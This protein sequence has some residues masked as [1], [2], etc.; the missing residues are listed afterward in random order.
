MPNKKINALDVKVAVATDLMLVGD[1]STG[2]AYKST[3]ANLPLVPY[4]GATTNVN[5]GEFGLATGQVTLDTSP[6]GTA[7]VGTTRWNDTI[8]SSETTLK[9]GSVVLKNGVDLVA[10]IVNKVSPNATLTKAQYQAVRV[11]GAQG[12]RLAVAYAQANND[13]NSADTIG[14]VIETIATNQEGFIITVGQIEGINTT[15]SLQGETWADGDVLYLSPTTAGAITNIKPNGSTGHIVVIGYVEYAHANNGKIYVKTMN[16]WELDELHNVYISSP[17]NNEAL[18]YESATSLW[19]NKTIATA[20]GYTPVTNARTLTI[21]GTTYDLSADRSWT[22]PSANIYNSDGTLT[23]NRIISLGG[24][25]LDFKQGVQSGLKIDTNNDVLINQNTGTAKIFR[26][27][28]VSPNGN[29]GAG[30]STSVSSFGDGTNF[31]MIGYN[32]YSGAKAVFGGINSSGN[33]LNIALYG[34]DLEIYNAGTIGFKMFDATSNIVLQRGG[35][36]TDAGYRLDVN[37]TARVSDNLLVSKNQNAVTKL[38]I[39]NTTGG[40]ASEAQVFLRCQNGA[41]QF[42]K[43]SSSTTPYKIIES[44]DFY[45]YNGSAGGGHLTFL[46]DYSGGKIKF[47]AG[48]ASTAQMT[49]TAAGRLLLGSTTEGTDMLFVNGTARISLSTNANA[50]PLK[51]Q[52]TATLTTFNTASIDLSGVNGDARLLGGNENSNSG[53]NGFFALYTRSSETLTEKL[54]VTSSGSLLVG[55]ITESASA[56]VRLDSTTKGFLPPRMT[57]TQKNAIGT[58]AQG[59]MVFDTTLVKLCVYSGTAWETITSI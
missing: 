8:G 32:W 20:L 14:L 31:A 43:T 24:F 33:Q 44:Y 52:N 23:A 59:L 49:L 29:G 56:L 7:A 5:L 27:L 13:N 50:I 19:K 4:T 58:P 6:T 21:N 16:G 10:R 55:G 57:T 46:N 26:G 1:P 12:Q 45:V 48:G 38:E 2:T 51:I 9:G 39:S 18:I 25:S 30:A 34:R 15:G 35:T 47:G 3:L 11:S 17:A 40:T 53:I 37:G 54:R 22:I 42:G 41:A 36:F 28:A